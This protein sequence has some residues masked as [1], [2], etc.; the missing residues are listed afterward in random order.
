MN[1][2]ITRLGQ[3]FLT[4]LILCVFS[5]VVRAG[6]VHGAVKNGT[7]GKPAA[8]VQVILIQLQGGMQPVANTQSD[9]KGQFTFDNPS[10]GAQPMLVR[11]VYRG[12]NFHQ[13]VPPGEKRCRSHGIRTDQRRQSHR[14][15]DSRGI[16]SAQRR[17]PDR[18]R[19]IFFA[20]RHATTRS[21]FPSRRQFR[22]RRAGESSIAANRRLWPGRH[23]RCP[24]DHRQEQRTLRHRL[25]VSSRRKHGA[26]LLRDSLSEQHHRAKNS[27]FSPIRFAAC[28]SSRLPRCKFPAKG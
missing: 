28:W 7:T 9:A 1:R 5:S 19:R 11:A 17:Q 26:L 21:L 14:G 16:F 2:V 10:L 23:A 25:R 8:G 27:S 20:E 6:T 18:R 12:I 3:V 15:H 24:G 4:A 13:P 22:F